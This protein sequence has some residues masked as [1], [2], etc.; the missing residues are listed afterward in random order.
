MPFAGAAD[1]GR[2]LDGR[3]A[4]PSTASP[5][6]ACSRAIDSAAGVRRVCRHR[7]L[8]LR[9]LHRSPQSGQSARHS[10]GNYAGAVADMNVAPG[11]R[12]RPTSC[13][14]SG[15]AIVRWRRSSA[16]PCSRR[17]ASYTGSARDLSAAEPAARAARPEDRSGR[18]RWAAT[19]TATASRPTKT[20]PTERL[21]LNAINLLNYLAVGDLDGAAV[22][23]RRFQ[24]MR[25]YLASLDITAEGPATLGTYLAG[26]VFEQRGEGDR[27]LRYYEEA[28]AAWPARIARRADRPTGALQS[29]SR[30]APVRS[31]GA[32][33]E[34][35]AATPPADASC[36]SC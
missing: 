11:R 1:L 25:D 9:D 33:E 4:G 30:A 36:W 21:S 22:E 23:A 27:A 8:G 18:R 29:V 28:L 2:L 6:E 17:S 14:T 24:V 5:D 16:A 15:A 7:R 31:A 3:H 20:P 10:A 34:R 19:S 13:R 32:A 35:E 12:R 26:F